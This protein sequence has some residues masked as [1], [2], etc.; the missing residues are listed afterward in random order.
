MLYI[1]YKVDFPKACGGAVVKEYHVGDFPNQTEMNKR[2]YF[3]HRIKADGDELGY[4]ECK[5]SNIPMCRSRVVIWFGEMAKFIA[6]N[7]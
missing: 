3:V 1:T 2:G 6:H 4:I 5:F 7:L